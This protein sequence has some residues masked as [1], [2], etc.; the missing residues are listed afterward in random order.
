MEKFIHFKGQHTSGI[1]PKSIEKDK[2]FYSEDEGCDTP[3]SDASS[4]KNTKQEH[5]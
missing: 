1:N 4:D 3:K 2:L 5:T